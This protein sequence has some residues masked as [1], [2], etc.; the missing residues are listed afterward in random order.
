MYARPALFF[1]RHLETIYPALFRSVPLTY[2]RERITTADN[3]FLDLDWLNG[4]FTKLL[5]LSHG[6]EGNSH[7]AYIKGM[8]RH[9]FKNGFDVLAWNY[10]GCSGEMNHAL[11]FYHSGATDDLQEVITHALR[12]G[13]SEIYLIGFSLGGNLTLKYLGERS[14]DERIKAAVAFSVPLELYSSCL[15]I[16]NS[17]NRIYAQRFLRSLKKKVKEKSS[18]MKNL[19]VSKI[20]S[21]KTLYEFDNLYTAPLH[22]FANALDYY[23]QSS[24]IHFLK[25]IQIPTLLV[26]AKNDPFLSHECFPDTNENKMLHQEYPT[27]GG[28]VGFTTFNK[29][30][31]YWSEQRALDFILTQV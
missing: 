24:A 23:R 29:N 20:D 25:N 11:R 28:H 4:G 1:N 27:H 8:A 10:R 3:D 7:R 22:G 19:D 6:L 21:I 9:F 16:S 30:G 31:V 26:S 5:I 17:S 15:K 18:K 14:I 13:Y 2:R 12:Q